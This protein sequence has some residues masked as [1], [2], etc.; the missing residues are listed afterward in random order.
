MTAR[1]NAMRIPAACLV[2]LLSTPALAQSN[3]GLAAYPVPKCAVP[4]SV[5]PTT[6]PEPP[7]LTNRPLIETNAFLYNQKVRA[8]NLAMRV[9]N[10][11][12][13]A[14]AACVV[15]YLAAAKADIQ[16]IQ[17]TMDAIVA[18]NDRRMPV[19]LPA[20][21]AQSNIALRNY[22]APKC[23][24]PPSIDLA[25][26]PVLPANTLSVEEAGLYNAKVRAYK[27]ALQA[28]NDGAAAY[29]ACMQ[30]YVTAGRADIQRIQGAIDTTETIANSQQN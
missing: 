2:C 19:L 11:G 9:H 18:P 8:Y 5:D 17:A 3:I 14:Y 24:L 23:S 27:A 26:Q 30:G 15:G 1:G 6:K 22:P 25:A 12:V 21:E 10:D 20:P 16:R 29:S 28:H 4:P 13:K 7:D